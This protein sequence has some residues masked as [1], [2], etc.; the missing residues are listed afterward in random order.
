MPVRARMSDRVVDIGSGSH[1]HPTADVLVEPYMDDT[2]C[3]R[4]DYAICNHVL[5]HV[6]DPCKGLTEITRVARRGFLSVPTEFYEFIFPTPSHRWVFAL[7]DGELLIKRRQERHHLGLQMYQGLFFHL[8]TMPQFLHFARQMGN[9][10]GIDLEWQDSIRWRMLGDD[11][12]FYDYSDPASFADL[13]KPPPRPVGV[14][15]LKLFIRQ[16]ASG[17]TVERLAGL[18]GRVRRLMKRGK[19]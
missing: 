1:P 18:R 10:F 5:E 15:A 11:E 16:H 12:P 13:L 9:L 8:Y 7:K 3:H 17:E 2:D 19:Q 4:S 14:E 6:D